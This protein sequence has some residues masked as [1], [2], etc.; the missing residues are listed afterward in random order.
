MPGHDEADAV[1]RYERPIELDST[2]THARVVAMVGGARR[3]LELGTATGHMTR[4]LRER[5]CTVVGIEHDADMAREAEPLCERMIVGDIDELDLEAE[6]ADDSFD[7]IVAA[8]VLEHLRDPGGALRRLRPFLREGGHFVISVPNVAHGSVRLA[9]LQGHFDYR[10]TGLL[11]ATHLRFFTRESIGRLLDEAELAAVEIFHQPLDLEASEVA[12]DPHRVPAD[13]LAALA[14]DPD[15]R[16]YQ[17]VIKAVALGTPGLRE[18][19]RRLRELAHENARLRERADQ[20]DAHE[21]ALRD[22]VVA[23]HD[24]LMRRDSEIDR[25]QSALAEANEELTRLR[26]RLERITDSLPGRAYSALVALPALRGLRDAR[27][28]AYARALRRARAER[29]PQ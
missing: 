6:L 10:P 16:T 4:V 3:V 29:P 7:A 15:A 25:L 17:F 1:H 13:L 21:T 20:R 5:G 27:T 11:D 28:S 9:L 22:A 23:A 8:D 18:I 19:Q 12:F 24:Q 14:S 2:S 26:V